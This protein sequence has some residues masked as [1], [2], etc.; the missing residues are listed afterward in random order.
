LGTLPLSTEL[1]IC[2][3]IYGSATGVGR[4]AR[5][6]ITNFGSKSASSGPVKLFLAG[7]QFPASGAVVTKF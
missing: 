6:R 7:I 1:P 4:N 5:I 3:L 2:T